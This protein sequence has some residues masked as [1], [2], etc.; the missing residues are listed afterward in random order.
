MDNFEIDLEQKAFIPLNDIYIGY[1]SPSRRKVTPDTTWEVTKD[2]GRYRSVLTFG[3]GYIPSIYDY[4]IARV[5]QYIFQQNWDIESIASEA[6]SI[7]PRMI[8]S[9]LKSRQ[10]NIKRKAQNK[11]KV[12]QEVNNDGEQLLLPIGRESNLVQFFSQDL[13]EFDMQEIVIMTMRDISNRY[14]IEYTGPE[15]EMILGLSEQGKTRQTSRIKKSAHVR[16]HT[17]IKEGTTIY[18]G[19]SKDRTDYETTPTPLAYIDLRSRKNETTKYTCRFNEFLL[20]NLIGRRVVDFDIRTLRS[21]RSP[22]AI[23]LAEYLYV[24]FFGTVLH[25]H[26]YLRMNYMSLCNQ[27]L[28]VPQPNRTLAMRQFK[29]GFNE[30][31]EKCIIERVEVESDRGN[32]SRADILFYPHPK[33]VGE[34]LEKVQESKKSPFSKLL[35]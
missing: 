18:I 20:F 35:R 25:D 28:L 26:E 14:F 3:S 1:Y 12:I 22:I 33:L 27:L 4:K 32:F 15:I 17:F 23:L 5:E 31:Q 2:N 8:D 13:T 29:S 34:I 10:A 9:Y 21:Y 24:R 11:H 19:N 7:L 16:S 6:E 30:L